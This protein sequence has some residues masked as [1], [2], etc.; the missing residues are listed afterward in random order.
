MTSFL[1]FKHL[2]VC[3]NCQH[4]TDLN[5]LLLCPL[6]QLEMECA[7][8]DELNK[9]NLTDNTRAYIL[10]KRINQALDHHLKGVSSDFDPPVLD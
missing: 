4:Q 3:R 6:C 9:M 1:D 5:D 10:K 2:G 8:Y 7:F